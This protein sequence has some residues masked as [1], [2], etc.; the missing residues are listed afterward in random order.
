[1]FAAVH[2]SAIGTSRRITP[3]HRGLEFT[4]GFRGLRTWADDRHRWSP[5]QMTLSCHSAA[6][7]GLVKL[8]EFWL[9]SE[10][11]V[12]HRPGDRGVILFPN[13]RGRDAFPHSRGRDAFPRGAD[14][15][16]SCFKRQIQSALKIASTLAPP[17]ST[18]AEIASAA[19]SRSSGARLT[20]AATMIA[21]SERIGTKY[22]TCT[23]QTVF[24]SSG[25]KTR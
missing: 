16:R 25:V 7:T 21:T 4:S 23:P 3:A 9:S 20:A 5:T 6:F 11:E 14:P 1:M 22:R 10:H 24:A 2:E 19:L 8:P 13:S 18:A 12:P 17:E 15:R